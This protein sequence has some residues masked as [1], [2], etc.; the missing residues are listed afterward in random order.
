MVLPKILLVSGVFHLTLLFAHGLYIAFVHGV[1]WGTGRRD[2]A[3]ETSATGKRFERTIINNVESMVAFV[4]VSLVAL[5]LSPENQ[6]VVVAGHVYLGARLLF[7]A[8]Y[9]RNIPYIRT[10]FWFGGQ[11]SIVAMAVAVGFF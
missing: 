2:E 6:V 8:A 1:A 3:V 10:L 9:L 5:T 11:L 7:C 4:P